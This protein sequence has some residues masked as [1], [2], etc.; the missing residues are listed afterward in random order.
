MGKKPVPTGQQYKLTLT[1]AFHHFIFIPNDAPSTISQNLAL[2]YSNPVFFFLAQGPFLPL[3]NN[4][5][6]D[7]FLEILLRPLLPDP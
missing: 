3:K 4:R 2:R 7:F 1:I 6:E 5:G